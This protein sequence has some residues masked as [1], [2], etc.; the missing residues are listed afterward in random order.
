MKS[1]SPK[2]KQKIKNQIAVFIEQI[3]LVGG[4]RNTHEGDIH[5]RSIGGNRPRLH[6]R[7]SKVKG[8]VKWFTCLELFDE[9]DHVCFE[10]DCLQGHSTMEEAVNSVRNRLRKLANSLTVFSASF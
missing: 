2:E 6:I 1:F 4:F 9:L 10:Q 8:S 7:A 5:W 3:D